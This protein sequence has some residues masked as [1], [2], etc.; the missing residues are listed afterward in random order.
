[1]QMLRNLTGIRK[2]NMSHTTYKSGEGAD[3]CQY[4]VYIHNKYISHLISIFFYQ[5]N[6]YLKGLTF[7]ET[8]FI[9]YN[10]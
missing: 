7:Y 9:S 2:E 4:R 3:L 10:T 1:M 8:I 5:I 6:F